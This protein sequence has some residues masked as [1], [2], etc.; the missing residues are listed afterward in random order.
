MDTNV[1][2]FARA[3]NICCG[4]KICVRDT[5]MFL[6]SFRNILCPQQMFP[7]LPSI[8]TIVSNNVSATLCPRLPPPLG[9]RL[10][11]TSMFILLADK[12]NAD[13]NHTVNF[14]V[15]KTQKHRLTDQNIAWKLCCA[16]TYESSESVF[17]SF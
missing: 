2:P 16:Y 3:R 1:S 6:I 10:C 5:K 13:Y 14:R 17:L 7:S 8:E 4:H 9:R 15:E 12:T 11:I